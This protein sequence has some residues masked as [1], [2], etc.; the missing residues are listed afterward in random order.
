[1]GKEIVRCRLPRLLRFLLPLLLFLMPLSVAAESETT[2]DTMPPAYSAIPDALPPE[3]SDRLPDGLFSDSVDEAMKAAERASDWS[4]LVSAVAAAVGLRLG[5][6]VGLFVGIVGLLLLSSVLGRLREGLGNGEMTGFCIRLAIYTALVISTAGMVKTVQSFFAAMDSLS[7]ALL[8]AMGVLYALG[9]NVGEA[10]VSGEIMAIF[11]A[12]CRY[13]STSVTPPV[14]ALCMAFALMDALGSRLTLAPLAAQ[15]KKWYTGLLS[16]VMFLLS[17]ALT[18]KI[19]L[20]GRADTWGMRGLKYA[21]GNWI[22]V[23]GGAIGGTLG[24]VAAGVGLM[25]SICGTSG[26][27]VLALTLLP[28]L[29]EL[30]L[31]RSM[32]HLAVT[33]AGLLGCDGE[34]R[35]LGEM[36][37]LHGY[38]A[39]AVA[40]SAVMLILLLTLFLTGAVAFL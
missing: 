30:L 25:R 39:A 29:L 32:L 12:I 15:V 3:V 23:V 19:F 10:A 17:L 14:C 26:V 11:L 33:V 20:A 4:Y 38:L 36:A 31:F 1:M 6:A 22:P 2:P 9:G 8:P 35:L 24:Q 16:L 28:P 34:A 27:I 5:D 40:I 21:V 13:I 37:S 18:S 7:T